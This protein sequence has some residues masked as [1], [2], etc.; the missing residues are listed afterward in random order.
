ML[1]CED[2]KREYTRGEGGWIGY[3]EHADPEAGDSIVLFYCLDCAAI[4]FNENPTR[5]NGKPS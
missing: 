1:R 2:C 5:T 4:R 3:V